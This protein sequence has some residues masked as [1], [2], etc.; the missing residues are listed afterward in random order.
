[1]GG[2][3]RLRLINV[4]LDRVHP[5]AQVGRI[6]ASYLD[7][8][9]ACPCGKPSPLPRRRAPPEAAVPTEATRRSSRQR[10]QRNSPSG[11]PGPQP[12]GLVDIPVAGLRVAIMIL[13]TA[14]TATISTTTTTKNPNLMAALLPDAVVRGAGGP[15]RVLAPVAGRFR[16]P[17]AARRM[18]SGGGG[19]P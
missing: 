9:L 10:C 2:L 3:G 15:R 17:A 1:M 4:L 16:L 14:T 13:E 19:A 6:Q 7:E 11:P 5:R 12:A 8:A 18:I